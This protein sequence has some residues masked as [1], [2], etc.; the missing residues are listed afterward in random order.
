MRTLVVVNP[1][2]AGGRTA[3]QW[4]KTA[5][6][7]RGSG[8]QFDLHVTTAPGDAEAAARHALRDG[9]ERV[10]AAG[11]D[12]T[13]FEVVN[14]FFEASGDAVRPS[15]ALGLIP[16]G[17]GGDFR[18]TV[19]IPRQPLLCARLLASDAVRSID[20]GRIAFGDG[21]TRHFI[22]IADCGIGGA[23]VAAVNRSRHKGGGLRG[24]AVFLGISLRTLL[25]F[26][27]CHAQVSMDRDEPYRGQVESVVVAN[28]RYFGAGMQIAP[29]ADVA[30]G[31]FEVVI[32]REAGRLRSLAALPSVYRGAHLGNPNVTYRRASR[33]E[34]ATEGGPLLFDVEGE[35]VGTTPATITCLPGAINLCAP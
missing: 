32:V 35:Q 22:N 8:V 28:G 3:K 27:G 30:D 1:T 23:V 25:T 12:G 2:S 7:L 16:M 6:A 31:L 24:T 15:A 9:Y 10:V 11:G 34:I 29:R 4:P 14:G 5:Q 13:L 18:R 21:S 26:R 20:A 17:T 19:G 33:V